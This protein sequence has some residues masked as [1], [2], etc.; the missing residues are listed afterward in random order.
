MLPVSVVHASDPSYVQD[1]VEYGPPRPAA[2][3][4]Y[5]SNGIKS[6]PIDIPLLFND[7]NFANFPKNTN[8]YTNYKSDLYNYSSR[9]QIFQDYASL[10][11]T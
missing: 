10:S 11:L 1:D 8:D 6:E 3:P 2:Q 5:D 4:Q 9:M 7:F